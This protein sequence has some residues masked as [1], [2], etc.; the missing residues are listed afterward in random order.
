MYKYQ[1]NVWAYQTEDKKIADKMKRRQNFSLFNYGWNCDHW[2][3]H[4]SKK[5]KRDALS[6]LKALTG[7]EPIYNSKNDVW[8]VNIL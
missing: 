1:N 4:T 3:F 8:E 2:V 7:K 6:T 5:N